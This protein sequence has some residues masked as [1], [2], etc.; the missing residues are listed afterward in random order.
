MPG[1]NKNI[2]PEDGKPFT[3]NDPRINREGRPRKLLSTINNEL[4]E[5][6][7]ERV[8]PSQVIEAYELFLNLNE[9]EATQIIESKEHPMFLRI[10][11]KHL[12]S[13]KGHEMIE[14][15]LDRAHGTSKQHLD[16]TSKGDKI[17][18][19]KSLDI[20]TYAE[21]NNSAK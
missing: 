5:K 11:L 10:V 14:K 13:P 21:K 12:M 6:G 3:K 1:G 19:F 7:F 4:K 8:S 20:S 2:T 16:H 15:I 17:E 9:Q 18:I